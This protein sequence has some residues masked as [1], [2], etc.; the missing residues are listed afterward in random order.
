MSAFKNSEGGSYL[1][2]MADSVTLQ[3]PLSTHCGRSLDFVPGDHEAHTGHYGG[4]GQDA[5][6]F[7]P[8]APRE[9]SDPVER[10]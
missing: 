1:L 4:K 2:V 3:C 9:V 7:K 6:P 5:P 8:F 10:H